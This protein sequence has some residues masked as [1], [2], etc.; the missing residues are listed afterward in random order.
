MNESDVI[1]DDKIIVKVQGKL[2]VVA[3]K[4]FEVRLTSHI[5][6]PQPLVVVDFAGCDYVSSAG[7]RAILIAAKRSKAM[8]KRLV[9]TGMNAVVRDVFRVSGFDRMLVIEPELET[10]LAK[11]G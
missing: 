9:L 6:A 1:D 5:E 3:A 2:D 7:L 4:P 10:A 8:A 11:H